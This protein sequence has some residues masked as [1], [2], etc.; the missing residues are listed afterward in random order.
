MPISLIIFFFTGIFLS[1]L[2]IPLIRKKVKIDSWYGIK[3]PDATINEKIWYKVNAIMGRY[4]FV[5]GIVISVISL[6]F[7]INPLNYEYKMVYTLTGILILGTMLFIKLSYNT[8][9][10]IR[11]KY[12]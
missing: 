2:A 11:K 8:A 1:G 10:R 5:F 7:T 3:V 12:E 9:E 6:N 4:L